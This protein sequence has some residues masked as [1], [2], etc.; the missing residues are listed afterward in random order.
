MASKNKLNS[1]TFVGSTA[2]TLLVYT[3]KANDMALNTVEKTMTKSFDLAESFMSISNK[4]IKRGLKI[5]AS[6]QDLV[7]S[8]LESVKG[9]LV[10]TSKKNS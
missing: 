4:A 9:K 5:S 10:K 3:N 8:V 1:T 6:Q 7:F 2:E